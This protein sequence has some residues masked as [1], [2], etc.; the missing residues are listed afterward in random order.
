MDSLL[1]A[2]PYNAKHHNCLHFAA[3]AWHKL[4]GDGLLMAAAADGIAAARGLMRHYQRVQGPT[5]AP[6]IVLMDAVPDGLHIGICVRR[7]LLH[8]NADGVQFMLADAALPA[9]SNVRFYQ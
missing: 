8:L 9:Y 5:V 6:S 2:S 3:C 1:F 4:T 7:R